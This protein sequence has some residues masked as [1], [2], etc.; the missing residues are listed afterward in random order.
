MLGS[1][2]E[3]ARKND[4]NPGHV[5]RLKKK[6]LLVMVGDQVD[7]ERSLALITAN[8]DPAKHYMAEVNEN[9]KTAGRQAQK[10]AVADDGDLFVQT[11]TKDAKRYAA[12][13]AEKMEYEA[14]KA[15]LDDEVARGQLVPV[16]ELRAVVFEVNRLVRDKILNIPDRVSTMVAAETNPQRVHALLLS[17]LKMALN[18]ISRSAKSED[19]A[20]VI[21]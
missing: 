15:K 8:R 13:R 9:Q 10:S 18:D 17:E 14:R 19:A 3:F 21:C 12:A 4:W 6:Q 1:Q 5:A 16:D 11:S 7:F 2:R 20:A